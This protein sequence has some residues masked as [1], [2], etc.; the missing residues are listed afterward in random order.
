[1]EGALIDKLNMTPN[2]FIKISNQLKTEVRKYNG[3]YTV[4]WHNSSFFLTPY[5]N[6]EDVLNELF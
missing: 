4:L 6:Y 3:T 2:E 1:M 5:P